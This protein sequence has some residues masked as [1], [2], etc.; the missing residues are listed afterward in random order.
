[1][2]HSLSQRERFFKV[3]LV[4][5]TKNS[6]QF[7]P[8][9][10]KRIDEVIPCEFVNQKIIVDDHSHDNTVYIARD[11]GWNV[12]LNPKTGIPSGANEA[13]RHVKS[14]FFISVEH[15]V[16]LAKNWW[17]KIPP[18]M[19]DPTVAV[20]QGV[21]VATNQILRVFDMIRVNSKEPYRC[22][23]Q[24]I[25]NT[26]AIRSLG[27]FPN[28][29]RATDLAL[30]ENVFKSGFRW[31]TDKTIV[32]LHMRGGVWQ[33]GKHI[34]EMTRRNPRM[35]EVMV[36]KH[37]RN[38]IL[39]PFYGLKLAKREKM[40]LLILANVYLRIMKLRGSIYANAA[41]KR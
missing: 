18:Y 29:P 30:Q 4:M 39:S 37:F 8:I 32:S 7:L 9:T 25:Y 5:W 38:L 21:R 36:K 6:A 2:K 11:F 28:V 12:F 23:D 15:D 26:R 14:K 22:I 40:P 33:E 34:F 35:D 10:L 31:V 3:D 41:Y 19:S 20:A 16:I 24:N 17:E 27:G 1:M 13:L